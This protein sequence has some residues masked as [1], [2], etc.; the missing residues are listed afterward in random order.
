MSGRMASTRFVHPALFYRSDADYLDKIVPF[1]TEG[2][3]EGHAVAVA[4]PAPRLRLLRDALGDPANLTMLDMS[5]EGRNPGRLIARVLHRFIDRHDDQYVRVVG[6]PMWP[7]RSEVEYPACVQ[8]E[9][10]INLAFAERNVTIVCPYDLA[11]LPGTAIVDAYVTHPVVWGVD[12]ASLSDSYDPDSALARYNQPFP[13]HDAESVTVTVPAD[14]TRARRFAEQRAKDLGL[15]EDRVQAVAVIVTELVTNS[16][17]HTP[18][19]GHLAVFADGDHV[20][21]EVRD[22]GPFTDPL[23]GRR[24]AG[25]DGPNGWGLVLVNDLADLVRM[26]TGNGTTIRALIKV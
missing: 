19:P 2:L 11:G 26:H 16:L 18:G 10:L 21:S 12:G 14:V 22:P 17:V 13:A 9:A 23:A 25:P 4:V 15:D 5:Q 6:E 8:H 1:V 3:T 20:V 24:P 7:G